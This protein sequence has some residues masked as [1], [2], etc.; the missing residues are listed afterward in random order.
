MTHDAVAQRN[1]RRLP[2]LVPLVF[3]ALAALHLYPVS[4][5]PAR[6]AQH[7]NADTQQWEWTMAWIAHEVVRAPLQ[8]FNGNIFAPERG[9]LAYSDPMIA[10]GLAG[11]P[12]AWLGASPILEF[13][14]LIA[15]GWIVTA[16]IAWRIAREWWTNSSLPAEASGEGGAALVAGA[17]AVYNVHLLTRVPHL[18]AAHIW[19]VPL[20]LGLTD[21]V[22][23]H[24]R[25]RSAAAL[26]VALFLTA[27]T[28]LY[29]LALALVATGIVAVIRARRLRTWMSIAGAVSVAGLAAAGP[30]W[31]YVQLAAAGAS[32]P[33]E[34][35]AQFSASPGGYL[36]ST[37][38]VHNVWSSA[39]Y[40][41]DVNVF[42][43]GVT[44]LV[45]ATLGVARGLRGS[46]TERQRTLVLIA[47]AVT[48]VVLSL[49]P[50][51][52]VYRVLYDV[53][54]PARGLRAAARFGY[55]YLLAI[56][57]AAPGGVLWIADRIRRGTPSRRVVLVAAAS[58][59][60][61][62][63]E[64]WQGPVRAT[65]FTG[66]PGI[67]RTL[68]DTSSAVMLVEVPFY[69]ADAAHEGG[70][71]VVNATVHWRP[72]MNGYSGFIPGSYRR[73]AASFWFFPAPWAIDE[74]KKEGATHV[75]VHLEK[76]G[77]EAADV[78]RTLA[79]RQ[80][81]QLIASSGVHRLYL[82][83]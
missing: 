22:V 11:A 65:P 10:P 18:N 52:P 76:F 50:A 54:P 64:V 41:N 70:E 47:L 31:P 21:R 37:S 62:T 3:A 81:F 77:P 4:L 69:P 58:L 23:E 80:D 67:Y 72:V 57:I 35:V 68:A 66:L 19:G 32:R 38:R 74:V 8:L 78:E 7:W 6:W 26:A 20:A 75:M 29:A 42:F 45:L 53:F 13:N 43:A 56:A 82:L 79:A 73:R 59:G 15:V 46:A 40:T 17:L 25:L 71:Y 83:K 60:L 39:F 48:G 9:V 16:V 2:A 49:G 27:I 30:L 1:V 24:P 28:S 34:I 14:L 51:T 33:M 36:A 61:V 5:A 63:A 12:L 44:A 55:L